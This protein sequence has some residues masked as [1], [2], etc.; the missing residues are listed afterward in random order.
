MEDSKKVVTRFAPSPTGFQH[1]GGIRTALFAYLW[2]RKNDGTFILRIED[3]DKARSVEGSIEH[4]QESLSWVGIDWEYGPDKPGPF[5]SCI[6]SERL[7]TYIEWAQKLVEKG[8]AYPDPYTPEEVEAF[9]QKAQEEKRAFLFRDHRPETFGA[10]DGKT[11]LRFKVSEL[12]RYEW[13]DEAR[14]ALS[15]GPEAL[16]D[17]ILI[18]ADGYPTYNLAHI[19]DD[20]NMGVTHIFRS[21]EWISSV[22]RF[23]SLYDAFEIEHPVFV[24]LPPILRSDRTK[25]LGKRDGAKDVLDYR[26]EGYL[27]EA[28][29]NYLALVGWNPG[30][31]QEIFS[32]QEMIEQFAP[33]RIQKSGAVANEEKLDWINREHIKLLSSEAF[34]QHA[35]PFMP[36]WI[37]KEAHGAA[38]QKIERLLRDRI[39]K[40]SDI[41]TLFA[42]GEF[43]YFFNEPAVDAGM[44]VWKT[45][46]NEADGLE[47]TRGYLTHAAS[48]LTEVA[49]KDWNIETLKEILMPYAEQ[50]G[51]GNVL[52]PLRVSLSGK[53]KSPDPFELMS[54]LG[55]EVTMKRIAPNQ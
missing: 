31:D 25:K 30:T 39:E 33:G 3:T 32:L 23:L 2:A 38:L 29:I 41:E 1:I 15:A 8:L 11:A 36:P 47:K 13:H 4:L 17:F 24:T 10:W 51:K 50:E 27:P 9:R 28:M 14:G 26:K 5:G 43:D 18:K 12:K 21:D 6:Q 34:W 45:L 48:L 40:F 22:P 55:K 53:E 16:D 42:A 52:W 49:D 19:V 20:Y 46:K 35:Y 44:L 37:D 7:D 54:L